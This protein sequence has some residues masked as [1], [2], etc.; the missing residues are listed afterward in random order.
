[1]SKNSSLGWWVISLATKLAL[2]FSKLQST[3]NFFL[4][5]Y[6]QPLTFLP[7]G[8]LVN[9]QISFFL[10]KSNSLF[11][12]ASHYVASLL[13]IASLQLARSSTKLLTSSAWNT[14]WSFKVVDGHLALLLPFISVFESCEPT[15]LCF[16]FLPFLG[17]SIIT[18]SSSA[19]S[20]RIDTRDCRRP[21]TPREDESRSFRF[22]FTTVRTLKQSRF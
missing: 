8:R 18:A 2:Y 3:L 16:L 12:V 11:I 20:K 10:I 14:K 9:S 15:F 17:F 22:G 19:E 1:M 7:F 4:R 6:L 21:R 13:L 5:T